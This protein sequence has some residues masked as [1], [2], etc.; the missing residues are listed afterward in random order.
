MNFKNSLVGTFILFPLFVSCGKNEALTTFG[1]GL[2]TGFQQLGKTSEQIGRIPRILGNKIL[3]TNED[4]DENLKNL[5]NE[6]YHLNKKIDELKENLEYK[7][8]LLSN[9]DNDVSTNLNNVLISITQNSENL[10]TLQNDLNSLD[11]LLDSFINGYAVKIDPCGDNPNKIDEIL[12]KL[13]DGSILAVFKDG[14]YFM[15]FL[16]DGNYKTTDKTNCYFQVNNGNVT[17]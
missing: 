6:L 13:Y 1:K 12:I 3:G 2:E 16:K 14:Q 9:Y 5:E 15:S 10:T 7:L 11:N 17:W 8:N 4:S